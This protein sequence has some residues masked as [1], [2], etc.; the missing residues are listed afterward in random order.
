MRVGD[1]IEVDGVQGNVVRIGLRST[2]VRTPSNLDVVVPNN[3]L[4]DRKIINWTLSD[5]NVRRSITMA[6]AYASD[7]KGI[8]QLILKLTANLPDVLQYPAPGFFVVNFGASSL[9]CELR[10]WM[11]G[12]SIAECLRVESELRIAILN[13][14]ARNDISI[15]FPQLELRKGVT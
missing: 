14:F 11:S 2:M 3:S 4:L 15:P 8:E 1:I 10:F 6:I 13:E 12:R 7:V 5:S 9:E